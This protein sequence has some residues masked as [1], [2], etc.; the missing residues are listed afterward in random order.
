MARV[1]KGAKGALPAPL[2]GMG[3][4]QV[5]RSFGTQLQPLVQ[6][7]RT[8]D[9]QWVKALDNKLRL[10]GCEGIDQFKMPSTT[11]CRPLVGHVCAHDQ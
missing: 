9:Y 10:V 7:E 2:Y 6:L 11:V 3:M 4:G 5:T 1:Y 8:A